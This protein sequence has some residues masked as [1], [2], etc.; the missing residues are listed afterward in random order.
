[1][2]KKTKLISKQVVLILLFFS[3]LLFSHVCCFAKECLVKTNCALKIV[4]N[5]KKSRVK[6]VMASAS[7]RK[8]R[9][10]IAW[11][12]N[13]E[14]LT[15]GSQMQ[16]KSSWL[17]DSKTLCSNDNTNKP[18]TWP[19]NEHEPVTEPVTTDWATSSHKVSS[20]KRTHGWRGWKGKMKM[21][22]VQQT[23]KGEEYH[24]DNCNIVHDDSNTMPSVTHPSHLL[25]CLPPGCVPTEV[26]FRV[27]NNETES[28]P[29]SR[30]VM[31]EDPD[32]DLWMKDIFHQ[33]VTMQNVEQPVVSAPRISTLEGALLEKRSSTDIELRLFL[34]NQKGVIRRNAIC[35]EL[36]RTMTLIKINGVRFSL[37][38]LREELKITSQIKNP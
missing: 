16:N 10:F 5:L 2:G 13:E 37:W 11:A 4:A 38:H 35:E 22:S 1:M 32:V 28:R 17:D 26:I 27:P 14:S 33:A 21:S 30:D 34:Q 20:P 7:G 23:F 31:V 29:Q 15:T 36:E 6:Q 3:C 9:P 12:E 24:S 8:T 25:V 18:F 19:W